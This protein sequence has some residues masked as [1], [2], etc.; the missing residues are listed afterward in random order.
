MGIPPEHLITCSF[1]AAPASLAVSKLFYPET[2][3]SKTT[4]DD[5][6]VDKGDEANVLDAA[7]KVYSMIWKAQFQKLIVTFH[8]MNNAKIVLNFSSIMLIYRAPLLQ[9]CWC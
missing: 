7:A 3:S 6:K 5:I 4:I 2:Q 9:L 8:S 1:M